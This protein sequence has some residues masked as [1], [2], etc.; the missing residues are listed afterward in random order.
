MTKA[1]EGLKVK[2]QELDI[3]KGAN[4]GVNMVEMIQR[5]EM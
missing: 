4:L 3:T 2:L 5:I 1:T